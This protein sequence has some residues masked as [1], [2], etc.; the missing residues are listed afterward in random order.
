MTTR[1]M[2]TA[3]TILLTGPTGYIGGSVLTRLLSHP[4]RDAFHLTVLVRSQTKASQLGAMGI[5]AILGSNADLGLLKELASEADLVIACTDADDQN[6]A[7]AILGGLKDRY[8]TTGQ[9]PSLIHTSGTGVLVD[10]ARGML[11][12]DK[13][14]SDLNIGQPETLPETQPHR[15]VDLALIKADKEG[16]VRTYIVLPG[17]IYG[18]ATGPLVDSGIQNP[19]SQQIPRLIKLSLNRGRAGMVGMGKNIWPNVYITEVA[20][21]YILLFDLII[22]QSHDIQTKNPLFG[23]GTAG[24][25]ICENGEH[26]LYDVSE[27]IGKAMVALGKTT[28]PV[29]TPFTE[30][31]YKKYPGLSFLGTNARC[32]ADR[33]KG[34][35]WKPKMETKDMLASIKQE[36]H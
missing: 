24:F 7:E 13:I 15:L 4:L 5:R 6:A 10:D 29:P 16:Y 22:S 28:N 32:R 19:H 2:T 36:L 1:N 9:V 3:N 12:S 17:T 34:I 26:E 33:S 31:E 23:H 11:S 35:G 20:D 21:L 14:Y 27:S 8:Q 30:Q 18:L 25:Y